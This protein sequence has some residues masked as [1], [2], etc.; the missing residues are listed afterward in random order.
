[1]TLKGNTKFKRKLTH[2]LKNDVKYWFSCKQSKIWK[3]AYWCAPFNQS[4]WR[5]R[6]KSTKV[7]C[8]MTMKSDGKFEEKLTF[9]L[10][11][12]VRN[13]VN[14]KVNS[15]NLHFDDILLQ[16]LCNVWAKKYRGVVLWKMTYGFK[17]DIRNL[18]WIFIQIVERKVRKTLPI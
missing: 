18:W 16:K 13:L 14:F 4:I 1:M 12:D 3:L 9:L 15:G 17:N 11:D 2:N 8:L 5:F 6:W 7:L 10:K